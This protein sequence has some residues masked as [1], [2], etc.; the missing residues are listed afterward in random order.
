MLLAIELDLFTIGI[1][2]SPK[3]EMVSIEINSLELKYQELNF[4]FLHVLSD[5]LVDDTFADL[6][7]KD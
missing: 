4:D 2:P 6:K 1:I 5:I 3:F 7:V